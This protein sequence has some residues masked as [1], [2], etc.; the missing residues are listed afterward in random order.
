MSLP[1]IISSIAGRGA[2]S[3]ARFYWTDGRNFPTPQNHT[4]KNGLIAS[5]IPFTP[6]ALQKFYNK[7]ADAN[8]S[9]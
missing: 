9:I 2:Y 3:I 4:R 8:Q 5:T 7:K 6:Q 1:W